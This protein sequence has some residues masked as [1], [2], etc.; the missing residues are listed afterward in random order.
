MKH[1]DRVEYEAWEAADAQFVAATEA[2]LRDRGLRLGDD[3]ESRIVVWGWR[4]DGSPI[5]PSSP[6]SAEEM[7]TGQPTGEPI[8]GDED[9]EDD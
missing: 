8:D 9:D 3:G 5:E 1:G 2:E 6:P 4:M 7:A